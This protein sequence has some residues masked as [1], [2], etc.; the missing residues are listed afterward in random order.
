MEHFDVTS[1]DLKSERPDISPGLPDVLKIL[2]VIFYL[3]LI[4]SGYLSVQYILDHRSL[5]DEKQ[6]WL[7]YQ[8]DQE[9]L[10]ETLTQE[11]S[12][13]M[14][15]NQRAGDVVKWI[16]GARG[17]QPLGVAIARSAH[18]DSTIAEISFERNPE[19]PS[20]ILFSL[21]LNDGKAEH[22]DP[23]L[24]SISDLKYKPY[25]VQQVKN[26]SEMDYQATLIYQGEGTL[27][28]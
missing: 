6:E 21:I 27:P 3:A 12:A 18:D 14:A 9:Q 15:E 1:H 10:K 24:A 7:D 22:L 16:E 5:S 2:P 4:G 20:Q 23:T 11:T 26:G 17:I 28:E 13:V 25:S 19:I 8:A